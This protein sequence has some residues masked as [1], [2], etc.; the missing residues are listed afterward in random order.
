M[1]F[2]ACVGSLCCESVN[3]GSIVLPGKTSVKIFYSASRIAGCKTLR[4]FLCSQTREAD[5]KLA[6]YLFASSR[7][8]EAITFAYVSKSGYLSV[9][10]FI[11]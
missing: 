6:C 10:I 5:I 2:F 9:C 7:V 8:S 11:G 1:G 4:Q 3:T